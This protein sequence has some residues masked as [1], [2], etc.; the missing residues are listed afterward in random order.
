M[1]KYVGWIIIAVSVIISWAI[2]KTWVILW[3]ES[4]FGGL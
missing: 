3:Y 4:V 1:R 2:T